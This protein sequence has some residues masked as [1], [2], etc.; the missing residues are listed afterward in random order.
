MCYVTLRFKESSPTQKER[1]TDLVAE[2]ITLC[3]LSLDNVATSGPIHPLSRAVET[4]GVQ[5]S[6]SPQEP[7]EHQQYSQ[8]KLFTHF[9]S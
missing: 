3:D 1:N 5:G 8:I 2:T 6:K 9:Y 7:N 4:G